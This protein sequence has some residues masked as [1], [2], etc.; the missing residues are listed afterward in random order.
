MGWRSQHLKDTKPDISE[1]NNFKSYFNRHL[2]Y[3]LTSGGRYKNSHK[4]VIN[5][6]ANIIFSESDHA[7]HNNQITYQIVL[8]VHDVLETLSSFSLKHYTVCSS[9]QRIKNNKYKRLS[10]NKFIQN[11]VTII[12]MPCFK[13][14][15]L[16]R[17]LPEMVARV[18]TKQDCYNIII[19]GLKY[20]CLRVQF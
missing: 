3:R 13:H 11:Q 2:G 12:N 8:L 14:S 20:A 5:T 6:K 17:E 1:R 9:N 10:I 7:L 19:I 18:G 16:L 4:T 15:L